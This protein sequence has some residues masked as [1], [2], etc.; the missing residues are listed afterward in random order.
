MI[1]IG[2]V[3]PAE[4][5]SEI[6]RFLEKEFEEITPVPFPYHA[7]S[8]IPEILSGHQSRADTFLFLGNT[9]RR[10]A[11]KVI[12]H[13]EEWITIPRSTSALLRILFRANVAGHKMRIATDFDNPDFFRLAL[14][15]IG[16]TPEDTYIET[17]PFFP[18]S[19][20]LLIRDAAKMEALYREGTVDFCVTIFYKVRDI[21]HSRGV[22]VYIL[23]PS[24]DDIGNGMQRLLLTHKL[25]AGERNRTCAIAV[26]IDFLHNTL[27][28][29]NDYTLRSAREQ[30]ARI[31][32]QFAVSLHA[33]LLEEPPWDFLLFVENDTLETATEQYRRFPLLETVAAATPFT[34]SVGIGYDSFIDQ[35]R[36][37]AV[38]AMQQASIS[39]GNR[40]ILM[41]HD[42]TTRIPI[43]KSAQKAQTKETRPINEQS[44]YISQKSGLS[45]RTVATL[46]RVLEETGRMR[47]TAPDLADLLAVTPRTANRILTKLID[48]HMAQEVALHF[49]GKTGRPGRIVEILL[50]PKKQV[51]HNKGQN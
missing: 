40:A 38:S 30:I 3:V 1:R 14:H 24:F 33:A 18:Y 12:P 36:Y 4:I 19:E 13:H 23:Q 2:I 44:L 41:T 28:G 27:P 5:I 39:G 11:E 49:T 10:Y 46:F 34:I 8:E 20:G 7:I 51:V 50:E 47:F 6:I 22:P 16:Y 43:T 45:L 48:H 31:L 29:G 37:R 15:E 9:A 25:H 42:F 35:A 17:I 32:S 26:H 21:L